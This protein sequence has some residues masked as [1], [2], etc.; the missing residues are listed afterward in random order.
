MWQQHLAGEKIGLYTG[1]GDF[2]PALPSLLMI[3]G[4]GGTGQVYLPQ[5]SGLA[6][7]MNLASLDL[8]GHGGTPGPGQD[9]IGAYADWLQGF[10]GAGPVRPVLL[11]HSMGGAIALTVGLRR[12][13]LLRGLILLG[14]GA[15]LRVM[16]AVLEGLAKDFAATVKMIV[17]F[18]YGPGADPRLAA[19]GIEQMAATAPAVLLGDFTACDRFDLMERLGDIR[20]PTLVLVG[21]QDQMTPVKY[22]QHLAQAIPGARMQVIPGAGHMLYL[23]QP[24]LVNQAIAE[25]MAGR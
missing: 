14:T 13:E 5:L 23:E 2:D 3:H 8:P 10:L 7:Q 9:T 4:A 25:F 15:R 12:P 21:D 18:S 24:R 20:L 22:G 16:P 17:P 6:G 11:G 19:Q 1:R